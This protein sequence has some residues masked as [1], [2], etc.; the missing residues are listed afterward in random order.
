LTQSI[1]TNIIV[2]LMLQDVAKVSL[3]Q[4]YTIYPHFAYFYDFSI[5]FWNCSD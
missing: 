4:V 3:P 5:G 2:M 1:D